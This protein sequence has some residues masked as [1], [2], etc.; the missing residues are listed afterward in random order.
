MSWIEYII[1]NAMVEYL[2]DL[3]GQIIGIPMGTSCA[4]YLDNVFLHVYEYDYL[5][6]LVDTGQLE[7]ARKL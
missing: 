6:H 3:Y 7:L 4:L 5:E 1:D 2:G